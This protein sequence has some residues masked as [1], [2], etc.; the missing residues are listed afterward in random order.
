M[1]LGQIWSAEGEW[2]QA[3]A[4]FEQAA[5][6]QPRSS[7]QRLAAAMAW[8]NAGQCDLALRYGEQAR[9]IQDSPEIRLFLANTHYRQQLMLRAKDRNWQP[10]QKAFAE[11]LAAADQAS[12][13]APWRLAV[14]RAN[15][16]L[17]GAMGK[18]PDEVRR[19]A[20]E[21]LRAAEA[22]YPT[23]AT[24]LQ[25]LP[26]AYER[27][28]C[29]AD[30]DRVLATLNN[31][32]N[33]QFPAVAGR[34]QLCMLRKQYVQARDVLRAGIKAIP[35]QSFALRLDL[36]SASLAEG[37]VEEAVQELLRLRADFPNSLLPL[38]QLAE[39]ASESEKMEELQRWEEQLR[40]GEG[41]DGI[42]WRYYRAKRLLVQ[43]RDAR[44]PQFYEAEKLADELQ[45]MR[46]FWPAS[47]LLVGLAAQRQG[48][49]EKAINAYESAIRLGERR[50]RVF[51]QLIQLLYA[52]RRFAEAE[53]YLGRLQEQVPSSA[54]LSTIEIAL[55]A[56]AGDLN[57]ALAVARRGVETRPKDLMAHILV[58]A[59][60]AGERAN[61]RGRT[62]APLGRK[63]GAG[64]RPRIQRPAGVLSADQPTD[65]GGANP[66]GY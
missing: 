3:A 30:A 37:K 14:L 15:A 62:D 44:D 28:Q 54:N 38:R 40:D 61:H 53:E 43:A 34:F 55:A 64:R 18:S 59:S 21:S 23:S 2:D 26:M 7:A 13:P 27:L 56:Q 1:L 22:K 4:A 6:L 57:R 66:R 47:H 16:L 19:E 33:Q 46:P 60:V 17:A 32:P 52:K 9:A 42:F 20:L 51:E 24:L 25:S 63:V 65:A 49:I 36:V 39:L 12:L 29:P 8:A 5:G 10:F 45:T 48:K 35:A 41:P 58:R 31:L 11:A 50:T